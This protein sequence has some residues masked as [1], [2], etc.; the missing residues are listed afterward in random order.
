[1]GADPAAWLGRIVVALVRLS[2]RRTILMLVLLA[3]GTGAAG[4]LTVTRFA[5]DS[6]VTKLFP[7]DLPWR[8]A[9]RQIEAAFP[10]RLDLI[11]IVLDAE[12]APE[13]ERRA[14]ALAAALAAHADLFRSIR[15]P[16]AGR[17]WANYRLRGLALPDWAQGFSIG[18]GLTSVAGANTSDQ[19]N[20]IRTKG[21][22]IFDAAINYDNGPLRMSV[23]ARNI[24]NRNYVIP[25]SYFNNA[26]APGAPAA[27]YVSAALR[28]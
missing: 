21:Y 5:L 19:V 2:L 16:D 20:A 10:Q 27:V 9:E 14:E 6:D 15:R 18:G 1:M 26:M 4:W 22:T 24:G 7:Q 11:V 23:A 8:M 25:F 28:F 3:L 12:E 17:F 13:A